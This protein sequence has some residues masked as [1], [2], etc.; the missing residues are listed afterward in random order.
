MKI[1][2]IGGATAILEHNGKR[3]LFDPWMDDGI[4]HGAWY[5]YPPSKVH[6]EDLGHIDYVYI[7]HIHEDHCSAGTIKHLNEDAEIII[8]DKKPNF[9]AKFLDN[10]QFKFKKIHLVKPKSPLAILPDL[11][12]DI[13][14]GDPANPM[15]NAIDST[16]IIRWGDFIIVNAN[17]CIPYQEGMDYILKNYEK[18]DLALLPYG[19]GSGYPSCYLNLTEEEKASEQKR[20]MHNR[21]EQFVKNVNYLK[22]K[23]VMPFA[24][25]YAVAGSRSDLNQ[26]ISHPASPGVIEAFIADK[27]FDSQLLLLNSGQSYDF[28]LNEKQPPDP[29]HH[30]TLA[31]RD[32]YLEGLKGIKY[33]HEHFQLNPT[34]ALDRLVS[35]ARSRLW[36]MQ[37]TKNFFPEFTLYLDAND[38]QRRFKINFLNEN[39][40]EISFDKACDESFLRISVSA[41]LLMLLLV[42]HVSWN[43][44]DAALFLDYERK[45]NVY[46]GKIYEF[47][48]YLRV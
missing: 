24:D 22:P 5:H 19:G 25:Q 11:T 42:G 3:I 8:M 47:I 26:Y 37:Q 41:T 12:V 35:H 39:I 9:V 6:I 13:L 15:A 18:I 16:L 30:F 23:T 33:D 48:N 32:A 17:D 14:E 43:I 10:H 1:L 38:L 40:E 45:P 21:M 44:A 46:D 7:S 29:Y 2:N 36:Q 31:D 28:T 4:F 27:Q 20:I 34:V